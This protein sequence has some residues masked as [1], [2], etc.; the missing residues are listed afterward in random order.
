MRSMG[1]ALFHASLPVALAVGMLVPGAVAGSIN[2]T[3]GGKVVGVLSGDTYPGNVATGDTISEVASSFSYTPTSTFYT[4]TVVGGA[5]VYTYTTTLAGQGLSLEVLTPTTTAP[6]T[7]TNFWSDSFNGPGT[8]TPSVPIEFQITMSASTSGSKTTTTMSVHSSTYGGPNEDSAKVDA[9]ITLVLQSTT[10]TGGLAL[11][12]TAA[13]LGDFLTTAGALTWDP[14]GQGFT[15]TLTSFD[16]VA[17]QSVPEPSSLI[18]LGVAMA[19]C[20][21]GV[22]ISRR[23]PARAS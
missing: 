11:P 2:T 20:G 21:M 22:A 9:S 7:A 23:K 19:T 15:G 13:L 6:N 3:F 12:G 18:L 5:D 10:Y 1:R 14:P 16:G 17:I 4:K 8:S